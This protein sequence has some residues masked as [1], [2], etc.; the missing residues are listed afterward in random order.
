M[1]SCAPRPHISSSTREEE[2]RIGQDQKGVNITP[3]NKESRRIKIDIYGQSL[4]NQNQEWQ[5]QNWNPV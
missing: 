1:G 2:K 4:K 5:K 3:Q